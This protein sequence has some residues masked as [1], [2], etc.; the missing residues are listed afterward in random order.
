MFLA[1]FKKFFGKKIKKELKIKTLEK[2]QIE[3]KKTVNVFGLF[4]IKTFSGSKN[5]IT[6]LSTAKSKASVLH[7][8]LN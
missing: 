1:I 6:I 2:W 8:S 5:T 4:L 3:Q 7:S